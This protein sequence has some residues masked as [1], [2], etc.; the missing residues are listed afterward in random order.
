MRS[1]NEPYD[2]IDP[3]LVQRSNDS[4]VAFN[5]GDSIAQKYK[6]D[7]IEIGKMQHLDEAKKSVALKEIFALRTGELSSQGKAV[8]PNVY[9]PAIV[10]SARDISNYDAA[11]NKRLAADKFMDS[12]RQEERKFKISKGH[13]D[14]AEIL[15]KAAEQGQKEI[16]MNGKTF[17]K[18]GKYWTTK[19]PKE[20]KAGGRGR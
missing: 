20:R 11:I 6:Q 2:S 14:L 5:F 7:L 1:E 12:L 10:N 8:N 9:G 19:K 18:S 17:Y 13:A 4:S 16:V 3:A 15:R